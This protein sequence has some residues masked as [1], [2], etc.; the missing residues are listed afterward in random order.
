MWVCAQDSS[1]HL[2]SRVPGIGIERGEKAKS[3]GS[4]I[5]SFIFE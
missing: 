3:N 2:P 4:K 1:I 5:E